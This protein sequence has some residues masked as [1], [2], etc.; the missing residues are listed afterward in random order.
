MILL[1]KR[2]IVL[3]QRQL[4]LAKKDMIYMIKITKDIFIPVRPTLLEKRK[5]KLTK[6]KKEYKWRM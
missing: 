4:Q 6:I 2:F 1:N 5:E 3:R